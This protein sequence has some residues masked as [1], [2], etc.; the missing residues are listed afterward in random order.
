MTSPALEKSKELE[1]LYATVLVFGTLTALLFTFF[2]RPMFRHIP[3]APNSNNNINNNNNTATNTST[4]QTGSLAS[5]KLLARLP[6]HVSFMFQGETSSLLNTESWMISWQHCLVSQVPDEGT[7]KERAR[8]LSRLLDSGSPPIKGSTVVLGVPSQDIECPLSRRAIYLLATYY[9]LVVLVATESESRTTVLLRLRG[10]SP[11][12]ADTLPDHRVVRTGS[13][14]GR[15]AFCRQLQRADWVLDFDTE[16]QDQ[17]GRFG[18]RVV[19]YGTD[20]AMEGV[21]RLGQ[22][23]KA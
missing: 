11:L 16:V 20:A 23:L 15:V 21:S 7:R 6:S 3:G 5:K 9:N 22:A 4:T 14:S 2:I 18:Y 10:D 12:T 19:L 8:L 13:A 1:T 17:L